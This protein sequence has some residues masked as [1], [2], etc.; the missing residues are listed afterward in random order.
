MSNDCSSWQRALCRPGRS[1]GNFCLALLARSCCYTV[2]FISSAAAATAV[3]VCV[4]FSSV[5]RLEFQLRSLSE[6]STAQDMTHAP[7]YGCPPIGSL[8]EPL[9]PCSNHTPAPAPVPIA[10][11]ERL[12]S[13]PMHITC[14]SLGTF[15]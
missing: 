7:A 6:L 14:G 3:C 1:K 8:A 4:C 5:F 9:L 10:C 12:H 11:A 15:E 2:I 13:F